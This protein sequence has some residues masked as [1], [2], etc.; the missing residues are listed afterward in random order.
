M[1]FRLGEII[2]T[3]EVSEQ[4]FNGFNKHKK[5]GFI[6]IEVLLRD[7]YSIG[8]RII[9]IEVGGKDYTNSPFKPRET[10]LHG[11]TNDYP[12]IPIKADSEGLI[13]YN[14]KY[15]DRFKD[16]KIAMLEKELEEARSKLVD[17]E[18]NQTMIWNDVYTAGS[19]IEK[20]RKRL[21]NKD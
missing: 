5:M 10:F 19:Y 2:F 14:M 1:N 8:T 12:E 18:M 4:I 13:C 3:E 17:L 6:D 21:S 9:N 7:E 15:Y 20:A 11:K 16:E